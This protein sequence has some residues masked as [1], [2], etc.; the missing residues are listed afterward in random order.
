MVPKI[1]TGGRSFKGAFAYYGHDKGA[2]TCDRIAWMHA[3]NLR[4]RD[5]ALAWK[6]M[7]YTANAQPRL[8]EASGH[9]RAGRKLEKPVFPFS[10]AWHPEQ[11]P[12]PEHML[13]TARQAI[14]ALGLSE[15]E[16]FFFAHRDE[17]QKHV[18]VIVNRVHPITGL[19]GDVRNSK[20]KLSD[21]AREYERE[22]GKIYC[23]QREENHKMR[24]RGEQTYYR[25]PH[26]VEAWETTKSGPEF[27]RALGQRGYTL[28]RGYKRIV[29]VDPYG[30]AHSPAR[31]LN[32]KAKDIQ[33]RLTG[34][35]VTRLPKAHEVQA[36]VH[37][38]NEELEKRRAVFERIVEM[39]TTSMQKKHETERAE[40]TQRQAER[41][42]FTKKH[43]AGYYGLEKGKAGLV[44]LHDKIKRAAWWKKMLGLTRKDRQAFRE[45]ARSYQSSLGR[46]RERLAKIVC[47]NENA[48]AVVNA[49]QEAER[50]ELTALFTMQRE[51]LFGPALAREQARERSPGALTRAFTKAL[52][53]QPQKNSE[54]SRDDRTR[55]RSHSYRRI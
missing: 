1:A 40:M 5:P 22:N 21:F 33:A 49:K 14:A 42:D 48:S 11:S 34:I 8:K 38:P 31:L 4:T 43:L 12:S 16:Q 52:D 47:E 9:S 36:A 53:R 6:I 3:E 32:L 55:D 50:H 23:N 20:R 28:A 51:A 27:M 26:I 13:E 54:N 15:H 24:N 41:F 29:V 30:K 7:A 2:D 10:L 39:R 35:D 37:A 19:A 44:V 25:D 17:P 45:Q 18:H 46:Y